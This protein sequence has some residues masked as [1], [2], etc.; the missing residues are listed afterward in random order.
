MKTTSLILAICCLAIP[1]LAADE[2][3]VK[4]SKSQV[5]RIYPESRD[6][7]SPLFQAM[8]VE[9]N[10][11]KKENPSAFDDS[12]WPMKVAAVCAAEL[13]IAPNSPDKPQPKPN[14]D[15]QSFEISEIVGSKEM[16]RL[17]EKPVDRERRQEEQETAAMEKIESLG[18]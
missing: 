11:L 8:A 3:L 14:P 2:A 4:E 15:L 13:G 10:R 7:E 18:Y 16:G 17:M 9:M 12:K 5:F 1:A 6:K